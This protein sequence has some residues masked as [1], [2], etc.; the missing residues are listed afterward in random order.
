MNVDWIGRVQELCVN[1]VVCV[2][3]L[4]Y[5]GTSNLPDG[6]LSLGYLHKVA[7]RGDSGQSM[8]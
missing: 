4:V 1:C 3:C 2:V 7:K 8:Y 5:L 6:Y